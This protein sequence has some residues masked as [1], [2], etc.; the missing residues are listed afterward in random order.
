MATTMTI[1]RQCHL[2]LSSKPCASLLFAAV[3][4]PA[5]FQPNGLRAFGVLFFCQS[6]DPYGPN[7]RYLQLFETQ[8]GWSISRLLGVAALRPG[9][10]CSNFLRKEKTRP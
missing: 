2:Y 10:V 7:L 5:G 9:I 6:W 4:S 1:Q 8:Y 3:N